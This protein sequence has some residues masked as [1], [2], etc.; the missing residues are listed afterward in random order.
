M[1]YLR[2]D[3]KGAQEGVKVEEAKERKERKRKERRETRRERERGEKGRYP[4]YRRRR[5]LSQRLLSQKMS[6]RTQSL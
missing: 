2:E 3:F 1:I 4:K 6:K 5:S